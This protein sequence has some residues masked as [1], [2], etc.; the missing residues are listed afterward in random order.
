MLDLLLIVIVLSAVTYRVARFLLLD[1]L[2]N[3][4]R[5][6]FYVWLTKPEK[7]SWFRIKLT[8]FAFC[9]FC[10]TVWIAA[11]A[12]AIADAYVSVP[13]PFFAWPAIATGSLVFWA[14][15]DGEAK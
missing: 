3:E 2:L 10:I 5:D 9:Q 7:V 15:I 1:D 14:Y 13:L 6:R 12:V 8:E 4:L 11:A